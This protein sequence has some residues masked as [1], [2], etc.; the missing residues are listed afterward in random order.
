MKHSAGWIL[1]VIALWFFIL[2]YSLKGYD[3]K[4]IKPKEYIDIKV[5]LHTELPT[6]DELQEKQRKELKEKAFELVN[7]YIGRKG[8]CYYVSLTF[9]QELKGI[10]ATGTYEIKESELMSGDLIYYSSNSLDSTHYAVYLDKDI[11]LQPNWNGKAKI[12]KVYYDKFSKPRFYR[13]K[14]EK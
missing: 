2:I 12:G 9:I 13:V 3:E 8:D 4:P 11:A 1:N 14:G 10:I 7:S 5:D 6:L